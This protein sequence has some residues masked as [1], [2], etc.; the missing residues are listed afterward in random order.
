M[1]DDTLN[2]NPVEQVSSSGS[3]PASRSGAEAIVEAL[4]ACDVEMVF[5]YSGGGTGALIHHIATTGLANMNGRTELSGAWMSYGYNRILGR[6]ASACVFHCVGA[7]HASPVV[8]AARVDSTPFFM[9]DVNLD[10]ALDFREGL[11]DSAEVY[12]ALKQLSKYAR[13][14]VTS[15]D[16]PLA[17]RQSVLSASTGRPGPSVLDLGFQVLVNNTSCPAEPLILPEPPA[18]SDATISRILEMVA[19]AK[20]PVLFVGAGVH[21]AKAAVEL[22]Q[23]AEALGIPVVSTSWG[24]RGAIS[25]D[26]PLFAGVVGSFGWNSANEVVQRS[27]MW[28]AIGTTFSQMTTGAWNLEKPANVIH[29]DIDP[30]QLG[31]IFQP[32]LGV[33]GHAKAV[34][35]QLIDRVRRDG[36]ERPASAARLEAIATGKQEWHDYH[37]QLSGESGTPINQYYLI[38]RMAETFPAGTI[39]VGDSGGQAFMLYRSFHYKDMTPMPL[40]SRYMSLGAGLPVAIG[41]KLAAPERTV[42]C[43]HGDGGFYYDFM[44]LSTLAE[45]KIKVIVV[46]DNNHCLY[47]NRQGMKLWGIQNPWVDL[48]EST[49]FVA[50]AKAQ[51]VD[52]ERVTDPDDIVPALQRALASEGSYVIDVWTDPETRIR[53]AIRDVI[54]ILSDRKPEQGAERHISPPLEGSWPN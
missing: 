49:D 1:D 9:M 51:G 53:R 45:R 15:D 23:F 39:M 24:G 40:G 2:T 48:P 10:N 43:Y 16:L 36:L 25:D 32:T 21:L 28:I 18:A 29:I 22:Q 52:G 3:A 27:D 17:V 47:A 42:V 8:H 26:H 11:Q 19:A 34:L 44:E 54:P 37:N 14:V 4:H 46:I 30:N 41:A 50:L 31:K 20:N 7:L 13:K 12:P 6:A 35:Q 5:G 38:R 33:T